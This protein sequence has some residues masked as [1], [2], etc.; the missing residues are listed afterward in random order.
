MGAEQVVVLSHGFWLRRFGGSADVIGET[1]FLDGSSYAVIGVAPEGFRYPLSGWVPDIYLT[2]GNS[3]E[4]YRTSRDQH[5]GTR[6]TARLAPGVSLERART[7]LIG[8]ARGLEMEYPGTNTGLSV[9]LESLREVQ[10]K[11]IRPALIVLTAAAVLV[12]LIACANVA[13][14]LLARGSARSR[15][16]SVRTALGAGRARLLRQLLSESVLLSL[17]GAALGVVMAIWGVKFLSHIMPERL[18]PT[19]GQIEIESTVLAFTL[20]LSVATGLVFGVVPA[21][22]LSKP[23]LG[24]TLKE[25]GRGGTVGK[26]RQG[27]RNTLVD[28][29]SR[30]ELYMPHPQYPPISMVLFIKTDAPADTMASAVLKEVL[31]LDPDQPVHNIRTVESRLGDRL[32]PHRLLLSLISVFG[33]IALLLATGGIY[34]LM[35]YMVSQR[36]HEVGIRMADGR[37]S[38]RRARVGAWQWHAS[39]R[40]WSWRGPSRGVVRHTLTGKPALRRQPHRSLDVCSHS[41]TPDGFCRGCFFGPGPSC[42]ARGSHCRPSP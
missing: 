24:E 1:I 5:P 21:L 36:T 42:Y 16:M 20:F 14:L 37:P 2:I 12:L 29:E 3:T 18:A 27:F 22:L 4:P 35:A 7:E 23:K 10:V 9:H 15:E 39:N 25:G 31:E 11:E 13:N 33:A 19:Y 38:T 6:V 30:V 32:V 41:D 40:S 26:G 8:I 17:S 34:A 28:A